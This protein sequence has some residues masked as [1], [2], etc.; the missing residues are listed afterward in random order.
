M[1]EFERIIQ[2]ESERHRSCHYTCTTTPSPVLEH[3]KHKDLGTEQ[4]SG[5]KVTHLFPK[6][7]VSESDGEHLQGAVNTHHVIHQVTL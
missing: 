5:V 3:Q 6:V 4:H 1:F 2:N 7:L